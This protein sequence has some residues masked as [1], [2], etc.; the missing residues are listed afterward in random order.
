MI[1]RTLCF[2]SPAYLSL[3][4]GQLL[5]KLP[6]VEKSNLPERMK[7]DSTRTIPVEDI[8]VV[9]LDNRQITLTHGLLEALLEN[10]CAVVTCD[11]RGMPVGLM[12]PLCGNTLQ[13][14]RFAKQIEA[15]LPLKSNCGSRLSRPR[16]TIKRL[17]SKCY[18]SRNRLHEPMVGRCAQRRP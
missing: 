2:T 17:C 5:I 13:S 10:N 18:G 1:K 16:L 4:D 14:E 12:L 9:V 7:K 15:S 6:E 11:S 3:K 8:G